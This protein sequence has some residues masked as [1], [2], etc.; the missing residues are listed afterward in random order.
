MCIFKL[1]ES[2]FNSVHFSELDSTLQQ[3]SDC[4]LKLTND[5]N[6]CFST[7][8]LWLPLKCALSGVLLVTQSV[9][10]NCTDGR[11]D[12]RRH[13]QFKVLDGDDSQNWGVQTN[14][15]IQTC[16]SN[17]FKIGASDVFYTLNF[18]SN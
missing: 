13:A 5:S 4:N 14:G 1:L 12:E 16:N 8:Q 9:P 11:K 15:Q 17:A 6:C 10:L 18:L 3:C 2:N 7:S